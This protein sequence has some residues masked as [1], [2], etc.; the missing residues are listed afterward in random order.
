MSLCIYL[1]WIRHIENGQFFGISYSQE[2]QKYI[3]REFSILGKCFFFGKWQSLLIQLSTY[4]DFKK[5]TWLIWNNRKRKLLRGGVP[6]SLF[7][8]QPS[9]PWIV[10]HCSIRLNVLNAF[11]CLKMADV[12]V[13]RDISNVCNVRGSLP[14]NTSVWIVGRYGKLPTAP[15]SKA[16]WWLT[17]NE[18]KLKVHAY[19]MR[20]ILPR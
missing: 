7:L 16:W 13:S 17:W 20:M 5:Y 14:Q 10:S 19:Q 8:K 4:W 2:L 6:G 9:I 12:D 1:T 3:S 11:C 18:T 15:C